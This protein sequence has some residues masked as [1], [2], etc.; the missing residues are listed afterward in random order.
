MQ[1]IGKILRAVFEKRPKPSKN[2]QLIPINLGLRIFQRNHLA[3]TIRHIVL[4]NHT[5]HWEDP[6]SHFREK[7]KNLKNRHLFPYNSRLRIFSEKQSGSKYASP[8]LPQSCKILWKSSE[9]FSRKRQKKVK[10]SFFQ[11]YDHWLRI[12]Q[13]IH[14]VQQMRPIVL[15]KQKKWEDS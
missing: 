7:A 12:F 4:H 6:W 5:K 2:W 1:N 3:P 9:P 10:N 13:V 8:C 14:L 15:Y 11:P